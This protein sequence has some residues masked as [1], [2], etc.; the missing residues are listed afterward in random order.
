M[1]RSILLITHFYPPSEMVAARRPAG[2][3]KYLERLGHRV[4]ILTSRAW[5]AENVPGEPATEVVRTRDLMDSGLNW[6][7]GQLEA[8]TGAGPAADYSAEVS[9]PARVVVPDVALLTWLPFVVAAGRRLARRRRFDCVL[10]TSG[11][12]S[13]HLAGL[14]LARS[15]MP[16]IA[17]FR[18]GWGFE[19][20]HDWPT[21]PQWALD[22]RL[23]EAVVRRADGVCAVTQPI[24][25][26]LS[27]RVGVD[28]WTITNGYDPDDAATAEGVDGLLDSGAHSILHA[29][30]MA[31]SQRSPAPV[32]EALRRLDR[33]SPEVAARVRLVLAGPL[34]SAEREM[35]DDPALRGRVQLLG[36]LPRP[37][38]LGLE[39]AADSLLL[40]TAGSRRGEATGKLYEYLS[41]GRPILV[42]GDRTE[43]ARIVADAGAGIAVAADDPGAVAGALE[44]LVA[45][46]IAPTAAPEQYGYPAI[47]ARLAE[48]VEVA[49]ERAAARK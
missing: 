1:G 27:E 7:R 21:A 14:A 37:R 9:W 4:T 31:S 24:A 18:D 17:D 8:W 42:L 11:P 16:W 5:G 19:S 45:G 49:V 34:T 10:T 25:A 36:S 46:D 15:G 47:A 2:F 23:E 13:V 44:R 30:R 20:L 22:R 39:Q 40:L 3:A 6:R 41:A 38:V 32:L 26:D 33:D 12:E 43:A 28:A 29:G 35:L 48:L